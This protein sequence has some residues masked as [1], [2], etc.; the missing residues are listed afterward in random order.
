MQTIFADHHIQPP[1]A[2]YANIVPFADVH[3]YNFGN[4]KTPSI[5]SLIAKYGLGLVLDSTNVSKYISSLKAAVKQFKTKIT[6]RIRSNRF[7]AFDPISDELR[8]AAYD[9]LDVD[10]ATYC[11]DIHLNAQARRREMHA[12]LNINKAT[13][14]NIRILINGPFDIVVCDKGYGV[15]VTRSSE[16][17]LNCY[18]ILEGEHYE[19]ETRTELDIQFK[20]Y[21][22]TVACMQLIVKEY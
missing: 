8:I 9:A 17:R 4:F 1:D 10:F 18:R 11:Q 20:V 15:E 16:V 21:S 7:R 5:V 6:K 22:A 12:R 19:T 2:V 3:V 13:M 14:A